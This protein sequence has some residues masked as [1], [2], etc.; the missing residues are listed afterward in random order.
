MVKTV[1][2]KQVSIITSFRRLSASI[3]DPSQS[4]NLVNAEKIT[5]EGDVQNSD[6]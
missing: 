1:L 2:S 3:V 4:A 6:R 5:T